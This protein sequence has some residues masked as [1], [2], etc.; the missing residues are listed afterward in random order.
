MSSCKVSTGKKTFS[1]IVSSGLHSPFTARLESLLRWPWGVPW[2]QSTGS[3][4]NVH[5]AILPAD[6]GEL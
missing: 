3:R 4:P 1:S 6:V 2:L 5:F